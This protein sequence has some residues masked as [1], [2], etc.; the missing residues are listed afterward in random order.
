HSAIRSGDWRLV[1]F[2]EDG[3][4][5]LYNLRDDEGETTDLAPRDPERVADLTEKL[6]AWLGAVAAQLPTPNPDHD[7][8]RDAP[9]RGRPKP[10]AV[11]APTSA[12]NPPNVLFVIADDASCH[13][14][15]YGCRWTRTPTVDRLARDGLAFD[16][17]YVPTSKCAPCR[18]AILTGRNPW[19]L[20][21]AANHWP[22]FPPEY[23]A[24]T[25]VL[26][27]S[28][29]ACGAAVRASPGPQTLPAAGDRRTWGLATKR[30]AGADPGAALREFLSHR[31]PGQP[32]FY[33]YGSQ[34]PHRKYEP[35]AGLAAGKKPADIDRVPACWPDTDVVRRDMLDYATEIEAFDTEVGSLL[36]ALEAAEHARDRDERPR[37]AVP[38]DQGAHVRPGPPRAA[39]DA[40][41]GG[42]RA[43]RETRGG[44]RE[45]H[46]LRSHDPRSRADR[47]GGGRHAADHGHEPRRSPPRRAGAA[48]QPRDPRS[49]A[50]RRPLPLRHRVGAR[51][52]RPR[53]PP[54]RLLLR[55]QLRP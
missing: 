13:F 43:S 34:N 25:E 38:E 40:L 16:N 8:A 41:A 1:R 20:E 35:D 52:S 27:D 2:Y 14:G 15:C 19:Q 11:A 6:D 7:P 3:R 54:R 47:R 29:V 5:E 30:N 9:A 32:F 10:A 18:A 42:N 39:C 51:L 53:H 28:G 55:S 46:R 21:A 17:A 45:R 48:A 44:L 49:R 26:A 12:R 23:R 31:T 33:W 37:N 50:E 24:F 4:R 22:T 36:A